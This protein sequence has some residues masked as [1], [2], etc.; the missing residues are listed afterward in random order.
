M[1]IAL[2]AWGCASAASPSVPA[3]SV[4]PSL[5]DAT[6]VAAT[7]HVQADGA[8]FDIPVGWHTRAGAINPSGNRTVLF[9]G[10]Q[11]LP[12]ECTQNALGGVC[13]PWPVTR[14][15]PGGTVIAWRVHGMPGAR[16][17]A[18]GDPIEVGGRAARIGRGTA[19][20]DCDAIGGDTSVAVVV[21]AGAGE[22]G[23]IGI[24]ACEAGPDH[25]AAEGALQQILTSVTWP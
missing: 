19:A 13:S 10:P 2:I 6:A 8:G 7:R 17:P 3:P 15:L 9:I 21:A 24:D 23:W 4:A 12:A 18:G 14:L 5:P 1:A 20:S 11:D 25:A 16:P 22:P